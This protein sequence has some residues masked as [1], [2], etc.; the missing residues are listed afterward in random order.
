[1]TLYANYAE[2]VAGVKDWLDADHLTDAQIGTFL[3]LAQD[4]MNRELAAYEMEATQTQTSVSGVVTLPAD[5]NRI[6][7]VSIS[8]VGT[9][10]AST[11]GEI[12]DMSA[13]SNKD[14]NVFAIDAGTIILYPTIVNGT[15][16]VIDYYVKVPSIS[17]SVPT[18]LFTEDFS[19]MLLW[20]AL[21]EGSNFIVEDD[22][23]QL[24]ESRYATAL[25]INNQK[26]KKVKLG[27][28]PLRRFVRSA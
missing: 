22:R 21:T 14:R 23:A 12:A 10:E 24:F 16:V 1:M 15:A 3:S 4:R 9:F 25:E 17:V 27:S 11:K 7:Q 26:P 28:T 19:D 2:W 20:A 8:G 6:R 5:F 18:N 13:A